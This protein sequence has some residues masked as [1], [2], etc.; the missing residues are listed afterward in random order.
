M[1]G[2]RADE[3]PDVGVT[4][5]FVGS[6]PLHAAAA[7]PREVANRRDALGELPSYGASRAVHHGHQRLQAPADVAL[8]VRGHDAYVRGLVEMHTAGEMSLRRRA[9]AP[10]KAE[11][12]G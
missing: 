5:A 7:L 12:R 2:R 9:Q 1:P 3:E 11:R 4:T 8:R 6:M 10:A